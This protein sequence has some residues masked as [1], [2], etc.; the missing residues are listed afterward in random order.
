MIFVVSNQLGIGLK[1]VDSKMIIDRV[2]NFIE[3]LSVPIMVLMA[4]K[5]D[6]YRKPSIGCFDYILS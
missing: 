1:R 2:I 4:T 5:E 3:D 6:Y